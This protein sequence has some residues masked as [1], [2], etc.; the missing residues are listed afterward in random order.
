MP[1]HGF[2]LRDIFL[3]LDEGLFTVRR[4]LGRSFHRRSELGDCRI[5]DGARGRLIVP[6]SQLFVDKHSHQLSLERGRFGFWIDASRHQNI[7]FR[8]IHQNVPRFD[9]GESSNTDIF[10]TPGFA[11]DRDGLIMRQLQPRNITRVH[12][13]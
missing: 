7:R 2:A 8:V 10:Q 13:E 11:F 1:L 5:Y 6:S 9:L 12:S 3:R 4:D